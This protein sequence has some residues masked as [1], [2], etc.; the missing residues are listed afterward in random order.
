MV[1]LP[2]VRSSSACTAALNR[3]CRMSSLPLHSQI[4]APMLS[5]TAI[6]D[7]KQ[8]KLLKYFSG[9][10]IAAEV[11]GFDNQSRVSYKWF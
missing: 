9:A 7:E 10:L 6:P 3:E 1:T 8:S 11:K 2:P 5:E 4:I